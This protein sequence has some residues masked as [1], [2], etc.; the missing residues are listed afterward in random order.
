VADW[1]SRRGVPFAEAHE[2]TGA[3]VRRCEDRGI[4]LS[5][6]TDDDLT[7]VDGRLTADIRQCLTPEAAIAARVGYGGTAPR[8]VREQLARLRARLAK[9]RDWTGTKS[10][11]TKSGPGSNS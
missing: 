4:G 7:A 6:V 11:P 10:G 5:D 3:L 1:L 9:Q 2:I 8:A